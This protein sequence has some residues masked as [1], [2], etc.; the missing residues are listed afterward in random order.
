MRRLSW[1]VPLLF[2]ITAPVHAQESAPLEAAVAAHDAGEFERAREL[3]GQAREGE[4]TRADLVRWLRYEVLT[5]QALG[6]E[7]AVEA[8][9]LRLATLDPEAFGDRAPPP[10]QRQM[11]AAIAQTG[12][13][14]IRLEIEHRETDA[15]LRVR[16]RVRGDLGALTERIELRARV[17]GG[18][19]TE[20]AED[21]TL[22][23]ADADGVE[24]AARAVGPG[25]ATLATAGTEAEPLRLS[26]PLR[27]DAPRSDDG[28]GEASDD[29]ALHALL[30]VGAI[31]LAGAGVGI[32]VG[33]AASDDGGGAQ[34]IGFGGP[35]VV[36]W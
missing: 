1:L 30:V 10:V 13:D 5:A 36:E 15:G 25:G 9:C 35:P 28:D 12:G 11:E 20:P 16:A 31:L 32:A 27:D 2:L 34:V 4:L 18:P 22:P 8:A 7:D 24:V 33:V 23:D 6:D 21:A 26:A 29:T 3:L 14:P 19:W 17:E